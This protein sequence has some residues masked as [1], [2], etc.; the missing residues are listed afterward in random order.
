MMQK[1]KTI[2]TK[3]LLETVTDLCTYVCSGE[4]GEFFFISVLILFCLETVWKR[5]IGLVCMGC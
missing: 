3:T 2:N 5:K 1:D 4:H